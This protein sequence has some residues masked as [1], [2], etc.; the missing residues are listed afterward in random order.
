MK[1]NESNQWLVI[2]D[3]DGTLLNHHNYEVDAAKSA[4]ALLK[5]NGIP[6]VFNT[7]KT[8]A[9]SI[10]L[11][12]ELNIHA[13]FIVENGSAIYIP[14]TLLK[15]A[16]EQAESFD[17]FWLVTLGKHQKQIRDQL[18][19]MTTSQSCY[20]LLSDCTVEQAV[21]LT[22]LTEQQARQAISREFSEPLL[23]K[24]DAV[25][26]TH[27]KQQLAAHDLHTLQGG[28]FL[29]I[30]GNTNKGKAS[31]LLKDIYKN[32][33]KTIKIIVL[34]DSANDAAMLEIADISIM[35]KSPSNHTLETL[36]KPSIKTEN[37]APAGWAEGIDRALIQIKQNKA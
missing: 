13:P 26:L 37:E 35:V 23:W 5:S 15:A 30:L 6:I 33:H 10:T 18:K 4:I 28:R 21:N 32:L 24:S 3:L 19:Q 17:D 7:S 1:N 27:F 22:G 20:Q 8:T 29:H 31:N 2:T 9:E 14:K 11:Q 36:I 34:G 16:P 12:K 25:T